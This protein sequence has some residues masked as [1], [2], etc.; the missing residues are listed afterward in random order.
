MSTDTTGDRPRL[1]EPTEHQRLPEHELMSS[2]VG[3]WVDV[4]LRKVV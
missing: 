4:T 3:K 1:A 2:L